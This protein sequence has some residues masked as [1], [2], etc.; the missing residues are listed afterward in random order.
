MRIFHLALSA[1]VCAAAACSE[2]RTLEQKPARLR[3]E[4]LG[5]RWEIK[6]R[7]PGKGSKM[8]PL[9]ATPPTLPD[10]YSNG[11]RATQVPSTA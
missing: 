9:R 6:T 1:V 4:A 11:A 10:C 8:V 2:A 5:T 3:R 7:I